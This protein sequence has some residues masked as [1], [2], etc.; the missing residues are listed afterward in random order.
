MSKQSP[1]EPGRPPVVGIGASAGGLEAFSALL[2]AL[3]S[4]TGL[5]FVLIQHL[6]PSHESDLAEI[7]GRTTDMPVHQVEEG[8]CV[9]P[10][11]VYVI[12]PNTEM[13][14]ENDAFDLA[15]R[16]PGVPSL[17]VD[18]LLT[19]LAEQYGSGSIG[20]VLSGTASD[21]TKGLGAI[22]SAGGVTLVQDPES[23]GHRGMPASAVDAGVADLVLSVD[24]IAREL[25]RLA[26]HPLVRPMAQPGPD[27]FAALSPDDER[28]LESILAQVRRGTGLDL[29]HYKRPTI[30]RRVHRRMTIGH[31]ETM[32]DY[33]KLLEG[34]EDE[35][36]AL[37]SE[38]LVR[39]T[40]FFRDPEAFEALGEE[41]L[42]LIV[43]R[44]TAG[45]PIRVWVPGC[46]TGQE[47][48]SV[49]MVLFERL[50]SMGSDVPVQI[51]ASDLRED[52]LV[53]ARRGVYP[54]EIADEV[55][56]KRLEKF[57]TEVE[58]G[59]RIASAIRDSCLFAVHDVTKD[60]PF[61]HLD[62]ISCRNLLIYLDRTLQERVLSIFHYAL[63]AGGTLLLGQSEGVSALPQLFRRGDNAGLFRRLPGPTPSFALGRR[64]G[65][66]APRGTEV[67]RG[68]SDKRSQE[69]EWAEAQRQL[70]DLLLDK[71]APSAV[72]IDDAFQVRQI[73]GE[74]GQYLQFH[75]G[76]AS[77]DMAS[78]VSP[79][80]SAA[81]ASAID[82]VRE[83]SR[84]A[85]V[86][87]VRPGTQGVHDSIAITVVPLKTADASTHYGILFDEES[88]LSG[89]G[90]KSNHPT[91][92][93]Y[94]RQE[95]DAALERLRILHYNRDVASESL[96]AANE[97]IQ[98]SNEELQSMNEELETAKEELQS[99]NEEL[100]T[101]N[102]ELQSRNSELSLRND[103]LNNLLSSA[104][105][106]MLVI[107]AELKI[108][109]YTAQAGQ[110][111]NL[112]PGDIGRRITDIR[113][114]IGVDD[115]GG[116]LASVIA[117]GE[118]DE[119]E[120]QDETGRWFRMNTRPYVSDDKKVRGLVLTLI[121][122]DAL[123]TATDR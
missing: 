24:G 106:A 13:R 95:L 57:F 11:N 26:K 97:E 112:I 56:R 58:D 69:A 123:R 41:A 61:S 36:G 67:M 7:L 114:N 53:V 110:L 21:G 50:D 42:P 49:A 74:A 30:I 39:V 45:A 81:V 62:L 8:M 70:D 89:D 96:R 99:T 82:E 28:A 86:N 116:L 91:E 12:P 38:V 25:V 103:D 35:V 65:G 3:P 59:Y 55:G 54:P 122:V 23:A 98:S 10:N 87:V 37:L 33:A 115:V 31:S 107:D 52:D 117:S 16:P 27:V 108:R 94:L 34:N 77:L 79:G 105:I 120:V 111:F 104:A 93:D 100:R 51:F 60:P 29:V 43:G 85:H 63:D 20:V 64:G 17:S 109:R 15:P 83:T 48:Y 101:L 75:P 18:I 9:E 66:V 84:P 88:Q 119:R 2:S 72:L 78:M 1:R 118:P 6:E 76:D 32:S 90:D 80:F 4:D 102:D 47:A 22:R 121:D 92:A 71:Y 73:R 5:A 44:K 19:S 68:G 14:L 113:W 46:A 40:S